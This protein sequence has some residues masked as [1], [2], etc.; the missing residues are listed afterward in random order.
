MGSPYEWIIIALI[1]VC[2]GFFS[3]D[4]PWLWGCGIYLG[5]ALF[6]FVVFLISIFFH[7]GGGANMFIPVGMIF[8]LGFTFPAF[9][10]SYIGF[11]IRKVYNYFNN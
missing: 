11:G 2:F 6:G 4:T 5:A 8:L 1:G 3:K 7:R 10:G 9:V